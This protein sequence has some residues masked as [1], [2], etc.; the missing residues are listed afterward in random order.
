M[1]FAESVRDRMGLYGTPYH[2][3]Y[4]AVDIMH[5]VFIM[6]TTYDAGLLFTPLE[7][8]A[9][10]V[11]AFCH[12][13]EHPGLNNMY[14]VNAQ[15]ELALQFNDQSVLENHHAVVCFSLLRANHVLDGLTATQF[16]EFRRLVI[17]AILATDMTCHF[18]LTES[19]KSVGLNNSDAL[20]VLL[21]GK[22]APV[23]LPA[24][25]SSAPPALSQADRDVILKIVLHAAD[26]SNPCKPWD[27]SKVWSDRILEEFFAQGDREK[28]EGLPVSPNMDRDTTKQA[29]LSVNFIGAKWLLLCG[30]RHFRRLTVLL[31]LLL[32]LLCSCV[33][34]S[35]RCFP[36][37]FHCGSSICVV[38]RLNPQGSRV[39]R[40]FV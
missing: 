27:V 38:G 36:C 37:R 17:S 30:C 8:M 40:H 3:F 1:R 28:A 4:H 16:K 23:P 33:A 29:Q 7:G 2:N 11:G 15:T 32:L 25:G 12:D 20:S 9:L 35:V 31:L 21:Q 10:L 14:Q 6:L 34:V 39:L 5:A 26:I 18:G 24:D 22:H 13:L 19:L